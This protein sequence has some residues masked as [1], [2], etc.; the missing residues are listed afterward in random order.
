MKSEKVTDERLSTER[1]YDDACGTAHAL[2]L[3]GERWSLLI[4]RE[5]MFGG[6][7]F[8]ELRASLPGISANI[9]TQR[10]AGL[11]AAGIARRRRLP[12]PAN[13]QVYEL[14]D[15]GYQAEVAIQE[16]GRWAARSPTHD[17]S[18]PLSAASLMLSFRTMI[19]RPRAASCP[20][21]IGFRFGAEAFVARIGADGIEIER[22]EPAGVDAVLTSDPM[23]IAGIVYGG[24]PIADA[25]AAGVLRV[26][27]D[28]A[29][30]EQ[31]TG[32]FVLP[33]KAGAG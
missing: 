27:G 9:L 1:W 16:L 33:P 21:R 25:E 2:E 3:V 28:R 6:R 15:W 4:V 11:E 18:L 22:G 14:T 26:E 10:L 32:L 8:S 24:R 23:T 12:P 7:R 5:L 13:V 30:A 20:A 19:D 31:V 29:I 17:P